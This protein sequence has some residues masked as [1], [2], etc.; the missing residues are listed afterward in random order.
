MVQDMVETKL[1]EFPGI[2]IG[3]CA[4]PGEVDLRLMSPS[5]PELLAAEAV[6]SEVLGSW[7]YAENNATMEE[8][9]IKLA[10]AKNKT[11]TTVESC[12]GGLVAHRL[13]NVPGSS[14]VFLR[15]W[16][17]YSNQSKIDEVGVKPATLKAHGAVSRETAAEMAEGALR[18]S[19]ADVALSVTG[20]AGPGGGTAEKPV[21]LVYIGLARLIEGQVR[22]D[23]AEKRL[24][25]QREM[26]KHMAS[27]HG[28]DLIRRALL[29]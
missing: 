14:L 12:T 22:V 1:R 5:A 27:Q 20:I 8:T 3:Y 11:I 26:F 10:T 18:R 9:V 19:M 17:T 23:V 21:G 7:I 2:E 24:F 29:A 25:Q 28:L 13:T 16:V 15:G 6:V 4:R